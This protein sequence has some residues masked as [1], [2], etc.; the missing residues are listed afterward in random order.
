MY[1]TDNKDMTHLGAPGSKRTPETVLGL[2]YWF[3][4]GETVLAKFVS[5]MEA[6][7]NFNK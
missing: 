6:L 2:M 1:L 5:P 3:I 4:S 7:S